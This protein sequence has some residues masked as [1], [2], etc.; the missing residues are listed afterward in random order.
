MKKKTMK[1]ILNAQRRLAGRNATISAKYVGIRRLYRVVKFVLSHKIT[2]RDNFIMGSVIK[3]LVTSELGIVKN[4]GTV[5]VA[6]VFNSDLF[7]DY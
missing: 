7:T 3:D 5:F 4:D 2:S 1:K 6:R